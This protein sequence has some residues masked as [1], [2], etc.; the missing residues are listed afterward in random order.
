M[1]KKVKELSATEVKRLTHAISADGT[2]Y[3]AL[4][5]VGGVAGLL[6]QVTPTGAKSWIL[7][8]SLGYKL[9]KNGEIKRDKKGRPISNRLNIGLGAYPDVTLAQAKDK[10]RNMRDKISQGINP[11]EE[12]RA[13]RLELMRAE[14]H[15]KTFREVAQEC[16]KIKAVEFNNEK[17]KAQWW[18]S[19]EAAFPVLGRMRIND[20][21]SDDV[22][23]VL[24]PIWYETPES[25]DRMRQR[26]AAVFSYAM[27]GDNPIRTNPVNPAD[28][29]NLKLPKVKAIKKKAGKT[30]RHHP[31]LPFDEMPR[32]MEYLRTRRGMGGKA[33][34]FQILTASRS[35]EVRGATW[36]EIDFK[37][38][39][40]R[41]TAERMK[42][43]R[44]HSVPLSDEAI[45][46]LKS[47][48]EGQ[49]DDVIFPSPDGKPMSDMALSKLLKD[50]H[51]KDTKNGGKG[52]SDPAQDNRII[53]P[54]GTARSSFK[55]WARK[56]TRYP[57][58][59]SEL[60]LAHVNSDATRSAY[61]RDELLD[62][63]REMMREWGRF[64]YAGKAKDSGK[65]VN[66]GGGAA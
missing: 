12:R 24:E 9:D 53:T 31:A 59:W 58:E 26:I 32:L 64:C 48:P 51:T 49:P 38:K 16:Y 29:K 19:V 17:H 13:A 52:Y 66:I 35:G 42:A 15:N 60:A 34:E 27:T 36:K 20:I 65:V 25:A 22:K 4:H 6:L 54:H 39:V 5:P 14:Q 62:E 63:R 57:D 45:N 61:A 1:P 46:L 8:A 2:P 3:N 23:R 30:G 41:L 44:P 50:A 10:A 33:L 56:A 47:L 40:W 18:A 37:E 43:D 28:I 21:V 7:R 11:L 55:E